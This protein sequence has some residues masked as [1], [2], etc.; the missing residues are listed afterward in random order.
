[1]SDLVKVDVTAGEPSLSGTVRDAEGEG[2][3]QWYHISNKMG[4]ER[5]LDHPQKNT[6]MFL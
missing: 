1:M 4:I 3:E 6:L 2:L 5:G